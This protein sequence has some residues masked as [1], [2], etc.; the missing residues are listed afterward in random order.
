MEA[1]YLVMKAGSR[2]NGKVS[3]ALAAKLQRE[4]FT[5]LPDCLLGGAGI[6][7]WISALFLSSYCKASRDKCILIVLCGKSKPSLAL[8]PEDMLLVVVTQVSIARN[9]SSSAAKRFAWSESQTSGSSEGDN[10]LQVRGRKQE[11]RPGEGNQ[12]SER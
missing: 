4:R 6:P 7:A 5:T 1:G 8:V 12:A 11:R 10:C 9:H 3:P 2:W